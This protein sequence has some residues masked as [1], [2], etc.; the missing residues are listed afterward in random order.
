[1]ALFERGPQGPAGPPGNRGK[2]FYSGHGVPS[3]DL[4]NAGD[5]YV[6]RDTPNLYGPKGSESW[7]DPVLFGT[8]L[9]SGEG[10]PDDNTL[11]ADGDHYIDTDAPALYGPKTDG[12]WGD[13]FPFI[14]PPG[15]DGE[16][17]INAGGVA[18]A[19]G[20][21]ATTNR[22]TLVDDELEHS[23]NPRHREDTADFYAPAGTRP[24]ARSMWRDVDTTN[25]TQTTIG[26]ISLPAASL[27]D[28]I[29][30][31]ILEMAISYVSSGM[32]GGNRSA[33]AYFKRTSGTLTRIGIDN[34][35]STNGWTGTAVGGVDIGVVDNDTID[36][37]GTGITATSINWTPSVHV[38]VSKPPA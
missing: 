26:R 25:A 17:F 7:G 23:G 35:S 14:L 1:M 27:G 12:E 11:G 19:G 9:Y 8:S 4:G 30:I 21:L 10:V 6:D 24:L 16:V 20:V 37:L 13:P 31:V 2:S 22:L 29:I 28:C 3:E 15:N 36:V 38:I 34:T 5:H 18:D 33:K 32:K